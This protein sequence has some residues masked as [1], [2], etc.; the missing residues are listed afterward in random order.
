MP[1]FNL[2]HP[3]CWG[4][5]G[6]SARLPE[7]TMPAFAA[8]IEAGADGIELDVTLT[9]DGKLVVIHDAALDRTTDGHGPASAKTLAELKAL[10][11][12]SW[13]APEHAGTRLPTL[14]E[15]LDAFGGKTLVN[16]EIKPEACRPWNSKDDVPGSVEQLVLDAVRSRSLMDS[17]VVSSFDYMALIN[18]R[19]LDPV[20]RLGAL[21]TGEEENVDFRALVEAVDAAS[22]H[23]RAG[24]LTPEVVELFHDDDRKV[25]CWTEADDDEPEAMEHALACNADGVF[26]ND[27]ELFIKKRSGEVDAG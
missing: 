12:G 27:V 25:Y 3:L 20:L 19:S 2:D 9:S 24:V 15:V 22:F 26:A 23:I 5:R 21:F 7:N 17:V 18:L 6:Y 4:H 13:L 10:D 11:A 16:I 8:A 1:K 14:D